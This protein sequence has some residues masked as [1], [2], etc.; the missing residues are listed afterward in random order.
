MLQALALAL[1][2]LPSRELRRPL[3]LTMLWTLVAFAL[4]WGGALW[5][6]GRLGAAHGWLA[7]LEY[8]LGLV[9]LVGLTW[10][11]FVAVENAILL[12]YGDQ[13]IAAVERRHYPGLPPAG[14]VGFRDGLASG[15]R[16]AAISVV[17]NLLALPLYLLIPVANLVFFLAL[18]GYLLG[19]AYFDAVALRRM[20]DRAARAL[21]RE[22]RWGCTALGAGAAAL[23][24]IP[25][26]NLVVP[27][28]GLAASVHLV[29][30]RRRPGARPGAPP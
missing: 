12:S 8:G 26:V 30:R 6:I 2:Q 19:R 22:C 21:W 18:N 25:L 16:L 24:A 9:L 28:I 29:E 3:L 5:A 15:L 11:L 27:M 14:T 7:A 4:S 20:D 13:V 1:A 17:G 10:L 23:A